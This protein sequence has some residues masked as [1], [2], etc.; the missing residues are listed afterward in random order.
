M[1]YET[2]ERDTAKYIL[3]QNAIEA[4]LIDMVPEN[5]V[6]TKSLTLALLGAGRGPLVR[7]AL[8]ASKN[9]KRKLKIL[10]I[11]KNRNAIVTLQTMIDLMW[12]HEDIQLISTD[13]R[14]LQL[15]EKADILVSELLGSF[16]DNELS[17][18]CLDGAANLLKPGGISIP[19]CSISYVRPI[20]FSR[21][22][23]KLREKDQ[24]DNSPNKKFLEQSWLIYLN[25]VYYIDDP[26]EVFKFVHPNT[27][28]N[29]DNSREVS[30][31][32]E[33]KLDVNLHGFSGYFVAKLYKDIEI[34]IHP[35]THTQGNLQLCNSKFRIEL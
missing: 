32:F 5:E 31:N 20:S 16:G 2:F 4:A 28:P 23:N 33:A 9:T 18:E 6:Q 27:S 8:N 29:I 17:P 12:S 22:Y 15:P 35:E 13:M 24:V 21:V 34:S 3:Y 7:A 11:D 25:S 19:Y 1:T 10:V 14:K 26:Q 30:L